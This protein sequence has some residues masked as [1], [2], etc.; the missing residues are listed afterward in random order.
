MGNLWIGTP[1]ALHEIDQAAK[2]FDRSAELGINE[3]KALGGRVTLTRNP[4]AVR[5]VKLGWELLAPRHARLLDRLARRLDGSGPLV[6]V[7]P[8]A[9][10]VLD[11]RQAA[12]KGDPGQAGM[13]QW[14]KVSVTGTV[15]ESATVPGTFSFTATDATGKLAWRARTWSNFP[16]APGMRISFHAPAA[17]AALPTATAQVDFK[18]ADGTYLSTVSADG[19][20][21]TATVPAEAAF[22]TPCAA[23]GVI[24]TYSLAGACLTYGG[25][26]EQD[27]PGD[28]MP[29]MG[30][31]GYSDAPAR[32]QPYRSISLDLVE[33][34]S[35]TG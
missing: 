28:G 13:N 32:P 20:L 19:P 22:A 35:A 30:I 18:K 29:P 24:G 5:R 2:S 17:F 3:F 16:V 8:A 21:V 23:P 27:V 6:L 1:G 10:N 4:S 12:G 25:P 11:P 15:V 31:T 7:D 33:V 14:F 9:G 34:S 26:A